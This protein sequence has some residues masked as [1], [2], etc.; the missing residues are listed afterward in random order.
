VRPPGGR[1]LGPATGG[2][3]LIGIH[4]RAAACG[5]SA[6]TGRGPDGGFRVAVRL[7]TASD[8]QA[9]LG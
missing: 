4:E 9:A 6:D 3:G 5:G 1:E 7:P 8:R 2:H